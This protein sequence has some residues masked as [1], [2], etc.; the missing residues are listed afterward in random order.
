MQALRAD[1]AA[2]CTAP[3]PEGV[4]VWKCGQGM[5]GRVWQ[6][7]RHCAWFLSLMLVL[8]A[9]P[10]TPCKALANNQAAGYDPLALFPSSL[11]P[12]TLSRLPDAFLT[13]ACTAENPMKGGGGGGG[14]GAGGGAK[15]GAAPKAGGGSSLGGE[16]GGGVGDEYGG[17]DEELEPCGNCGRKMR[18]DALVKHQKVWTGEGVDRSGQV[19]EV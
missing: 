19:W 17:G 15:P 5:L 1:D 9:R 18:P 3:A 12:D 13:Q 16:H 7:S 6:M 14:G 8:P 11:A 4:E 2:R 10:C